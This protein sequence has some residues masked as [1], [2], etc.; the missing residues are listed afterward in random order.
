MSEVGKVRSNPGPNTRNEARC[1]HGTG[2]GGITLICDT[3]AVHGVVVRRPRECLACQSMVE[4]HGSFE[5]IWRDVSPRQLRIETRNYRRRTDRRMQKWMTHTKLHIRIFN[6][7]NFS[8]NRI[9]ECFGSS[10]TRSSPVLRWIEVLK[11]VRHQSCG[12][13]G[14]VNAALAAAAAQARGHI[15]P[16]GGP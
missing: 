5:R 16:K 15:C 14:S 10:K 8:T 11:R 1:G 2:G 3:R 6:D 12:G 9:K 7:I 4:G 13:L